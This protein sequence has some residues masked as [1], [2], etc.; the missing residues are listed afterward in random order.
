ME[1]KKKILIS[2]WI[3]RSNIF[4]QGADKASKGLRGR[5]HGSGGE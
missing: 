5:P 1:T 4:L 3:N 2:G